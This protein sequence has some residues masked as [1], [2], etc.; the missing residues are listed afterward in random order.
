MIAPIKPP[1]TILDSIKTC[2]KGYLNF[3][4]R[5]RIS[6]LWPFYI[7]REIIFLIFYILMIVFTKEEKRHPA[8]W[9]TIT[10]RVPDNNGFYAVMILELLFSLGTLLPLIAASTRR[11]HDAGSSGWWILCYLIPLVGLVIVWFLWCRDLFIWCKFLWT[12]DKI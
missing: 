10:S 2:L 6:E 11:L 1:L 3:K 5:G 12:S 7:I 4:G 8:S 9:I